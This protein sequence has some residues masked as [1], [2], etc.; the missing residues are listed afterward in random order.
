MLADQN[1]WY[2]SSVKVIFYIWFVFFSEKKIQI[3]CLISLFFVFTAN[4][5]LITRY[6]AKRQDQLPSITALRP[7]Q[8]SLQPAKRRKF[9]AMNN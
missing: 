2:L 6:N 5:K 8:S 3:F 1:A 9:W 7:Y 4:S